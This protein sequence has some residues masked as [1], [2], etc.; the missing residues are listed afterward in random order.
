MAKKKKLKL[1][2]DRVI[3]VAVIGIALVFGIV[4]GISFATMT[5]MGFF[6]KPNDTTTSTN[7]PQ[8]KGVVILDPGHGG[9]DVGAN[10]GTLY[11]KDI[12]LTTAKEIAKKLEEKNIKAILTR[13]TDTALHDD[14]ITDLKMRAD[15]SVQHKADYFVSI[16]V[17]SFDKSNDVT[18]FEVYTKNESSQPLASSIGTYIEKL[19]YSKNRGLQ[20]G[21]TL[22][23]LRDNT[24]PSVLIELG[25]IKGKDF[26]YLNDNQ[27][28]AQ[29]GDAIAEGISQQINQK[30]N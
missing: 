26:N 3:L 7:D 11:E 4:K 10:R 29:I 28:L 2:I 5:V 21:G 24:V 8:Y 6:E 1:R 12:S 27:K 30:T 18:G 16:H 23:V 20:D 17:N 9:Y 19:N 25:Y 13:T 15:F 22:A 14:K